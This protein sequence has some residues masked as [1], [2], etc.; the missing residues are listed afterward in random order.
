MSGRSSGETPNLVMRKTTDN[1]FV[2]SSST[3]HL[4]HCL[5]QPPPQCCTA[6]ANTSQSKFPRPALFN[7]LEKFTQNIRVCWRSPADAR[8]VP[9]VGFIAFYF[10]SPPSIDTPRPSP[11]T[12]TVQAA[13]RPSLIHGLPPLK[14]RPFAQAHA[15]LVRSHITTHCYSATCQMTWSP[16]TTSGQA[17]WRLAP[18]HPPP[19]CDLPRGI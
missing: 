10:S 13:L 14:T 7:L 2:K 16:I 1:Y 12:Y 5:A 3:P 11:I 19:R 17:A 8:A 9:R 4:P 6:R 15:P 18:S